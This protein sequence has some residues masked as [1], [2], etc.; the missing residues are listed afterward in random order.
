[1]LITQSNFYS[2]AASYSSSSAT[3]PGASEASLALAVS[4][5]DVSQCAPPEN[6]CANWSFAAALSANFEDPYLL[7]PGG[8]KDGGGSSAAPS[9]S[10]AIA[11]SEVAPAETP[12][13][14]AKAEAKAAPDACRASGGNLKLDGLLSGREVKPAECCPTEKKDASTQECKMDSKPDSSAASRAEPKSGPSESAKGGSSGSSAGS[15][16]ASSGGGGDKK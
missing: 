16:S 6:E 13:A 2:L 15:G 11:R 1:M 7:L 3:T 10:L 8:S 9:A 5:S 12:Q 4:T 14:E